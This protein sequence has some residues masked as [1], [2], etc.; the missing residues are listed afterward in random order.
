MSELLQITELEAPLVADLEGAA[1]PSKD[2][3]THGEGAGSTP[4]IYLTLAVCVLDVVAALGCWFGAFS[5]SPTML[6]SGDIVAAYSVPGTLWD[7]VALALLRTAII[8]VLV[9]HR[10]STLRAVRHATAAAFLL[11]TGAFAATKAVWAV[12]ESVVAVSGS[13]AG[14][15]AASGS[16][17]TAPTSAPSA[18][19]PG[20]ALASPSWARI[21]LPAVALLCSVAHLLALTMRNCALQAARY[22]R[23]RRARRSRGDKD[24]D[25]SGNTKDAASGWRRLMRLA[26]LALPESTWLV[27]GCI[28]LLIRLPFSL[29][30]PHFVATTIEALAG[31]EHSIAEHTASAGGWSTPAVL[32]VRHAITCLFIVGCVDAALDF[33]CVFLFGVCQQRV[34]RNLRCKLFDAV[35]AQEVGF[36]DKTSTGDVTSRLTADTSAMANDLTWVFRFSIESSVRIGGIA[37]YMFVR[38]WQLALVTCIALPITAFVNYFYGKWLRGNASKVQDALSASNVIAHEVIGSIRAVFAFAQ[39]GV[40]SARYR[41]AIETYYKLNVQQTAMQAGYYM[42]VSTWLVQVC[43]QSAILGYGAVLIVR[44]PHVLTSGAL[45]AFMLYQSQLQ[46]YCC[47]LL[48]SYTRLIMGTGAGAKVFDLIDRQ[49][50]RTPSRGVIPNVAAVAALA[51][52]AA[53]SAAAEGSSRN[54]TPVSVSPR[55][56][57]SAASPMPFAVQFDHVSF[58]YPSRSDTPVLNAL[59]FAMRPGQMFAL[60]GASGAGKSTTFHLLEQFYEAT[61]GTVRVWGEDVR[62]VSRRWFHRTAALVGQEP[63]LFSGSVRGNILFALRDDDDPLV[64]STVAAMA[65]LDR[66]AVEGMD[67]VSVPATVRE[68]ELRAAWRSL[69]HR[70]EEAARVANAHSFVSALPSGYAT[71]VG[72]RGVQLSGGQRQ[73]I[74]IARAI[75][76][77]PQL[78][79]LDEATSNLDSD[80]ER[81]VQQALERVMVGRT[82]LVIAHRL[83]TIQGADSI[84]VLDKGRLV[85]QGTHEELL[86]REGAYAFLAQ[87]QLF[88]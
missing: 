26:L 7:L 69:Q 50:D 78:L 77:D 48:D 73:R 41:G 25:A 80:S 87:R 13:A 54:T 23:E 53:A 29:A 46:S 2:H 66:D 79:L 61:A 33:G 58:A 81:L 72:E 63:T 84:L 68:P 47:Q 42:A 9:A 6:W 3:I 43:V 5:F 56:S 86:E 19:A 39:S 10:R 65:A 31:I 38:S 14:A 88:A 57:S 62:H 49:P 83:S 82:T 4:L 8:V 34:I 32:Q 59:S 85:E 51:S 27:S 35:L 74:A 22:E 76:T 12:H 20:S 24:G 45:L 21:V 16:N 15:H 30:Q 18:A 11:I 28:V 75:M 64:C 67:V 71:Q 44:A 40:E 70:M 60:V 1:A 52:A 36:F 37:A 17:S 55:T